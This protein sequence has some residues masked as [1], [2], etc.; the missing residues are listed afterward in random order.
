MSLL[1]WAV[2]PTA[3]VSFQN[4]S[5]KRVIQHTHTSTSSGMNVSVSK[6]TETHII[7]LTL[8]HITISR[9]HSVPNDSPIDTCEHPLMY[10]YEHELS[11]LCTCACITRMDAHQHTQSC[12]QAHIHKCIQTCTDT[13]IHAHKPVTKILRHAHT[14]AEMYTHTSSEMHTYK[15][16]LICNHTQT[17]TE[18]HTDTGRHSYEQR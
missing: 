5:S 15:T 2:L 14:R 13:Y 8:M 18:I 1:P 17:N 4:H 16:I 6:H 10:T 7:P 9:P 12:T 11:Y 3:L